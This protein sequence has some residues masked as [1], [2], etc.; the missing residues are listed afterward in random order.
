[1]KLFETKKAERKTAEIITFGFSI[2][3]LV[4]IAY[5]LIHQGNTNNHSNFLQLSSVL[6][7]EEMKKE[8]EFYILPLKIHNNGKTAARVQIHVDLGEGES[9]RERSIDLDYLDKQGDQ[10]IYLNLRNEPKAE[11]IKVTPLFYYFD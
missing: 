7:F 4:G 10:T 9:P 3:L 2:A 11:A 8:G 6:K 1:M 5:F